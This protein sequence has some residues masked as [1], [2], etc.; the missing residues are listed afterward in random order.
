[1]IRRFVRNTVVL[2]LASL[3]I[4]SCQLCLFPTRPSLLIL[5]GIL[6][7]QGHSWVGYPE[8]NRSLYTQH[9]FSVALFRL[10]YLLLS[11]RFHPVVH[12]GERYFPL[13]HRTSHIVVVVLSLRRTHGRVDG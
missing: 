7:G 8:S 5:V 13:C 1:M 6:P 11:H 9:R 2:R 3:P 4:A 12:F 10:G